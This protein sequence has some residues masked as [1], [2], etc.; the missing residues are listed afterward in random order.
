VW[1]NCKKKI[2][3]FSFLL[4]FYFLRADMKYIITYGEKIKWLGWGRGGGEKAHSG[5]LYSYIYRNGRQRGED[6]FILTDGHLGT[7]GVVFTPER[8]KEGVLNKCSG[9][10]FWTFGFAPRP[11]EAPE[12]VGL[13]REK[14][15]TKEIK[16]IIIM[17]KGKGTLSRRWRFW[18]T[19]CSCDLFFSSVGLHSVCFLIFRLRAK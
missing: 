12:V 17:I 8:R 6:H 11:S 13:D 7:R 4:W 9:H 2:L 19:S 14:L 5:V 15:L 16:R 10:A 18:N 3:G 1:T